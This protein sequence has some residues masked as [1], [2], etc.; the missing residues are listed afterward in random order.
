MRS[1]L[2]E[3]G[4]TSS[5][6]ITRAIASAPFESCSSLDD[7]MLFARKILARDWQVT[8]AERCAKVLG[9]ELHLI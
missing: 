6:T 7:P 2:R 3:G 9:Y 5:P 1:H 8:S 4:T